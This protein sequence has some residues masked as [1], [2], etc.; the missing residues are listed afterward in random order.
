ML[1]N[2][3]PISSNA[4]FVLPCTHPLQPFLL[5]GPDG[6]REART[7]KGGA[8]AYFPVLSS[9]WACWGLLTHVG[10]PSATSFMYNPGGKG[11]GFIPLL[12]KCPTGVPG[13]AMQA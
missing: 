3:L 13:K 5:E 10:A 9:S 8:P 11:C 6:T 12:N 4:Y 1:K 7:T 2:K